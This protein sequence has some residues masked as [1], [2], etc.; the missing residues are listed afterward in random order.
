MTAVR[1][2]DPAPSLAR[3]GRRDDLITALFGVWITLGGYIDGF[4]HRNLDTP[5]TFFTPWH[6][7]LYSGYLATAAWVLWLVARRSEGGRWSIPD[8]YA[9][10]V[11]G[12]GLFALGGVGDMLWHVF[13]GIEVAIDALLSPT[14]LLLL[15]GALLILSG[16]IRSAWRDR[17]YQPVRLSSFW[18]PLLA[19]TMV[20]AEIGF[21][22]QYMDGF[23]ARVMQASYLPGGEEG[24]LEAVYGIASILVTTVVLMG[25]LMLALRRW[26]LPFGSGLVL[27]GLTGVLM[28]LLEG[29]EFPEDLIA[30]LAGGLAL[31]LLIRW[32][33][34]GPDRTTALRWVGFGVPVVMWGARFAVFAAIYGI[35]WPTSMW[36]GIVVMAGLAGLGLSLLTFPPGRSGSL[37]TTA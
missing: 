21:F 26:R 4:A 30:P 17:S 9:T 19:L 1:S 11:A 2:S 15:V 18:P 25:V 13:F 27:F 37:P 12:I 36:T 3:T 10:S 34:P 5:E 16:P 8:G 28:E 22:F 7:I 31:D 6:G 35:G 29:Y 33:Q 24:S 20:A 32:L 23:S 14:H